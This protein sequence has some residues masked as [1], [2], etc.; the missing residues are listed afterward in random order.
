MLVS[1]HSLPRSDPAVEM[2]GAVGA[3]GMLGLVIV[4]VRA[5]AGYC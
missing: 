5:V 3:L 1:A 4:Y 2:M